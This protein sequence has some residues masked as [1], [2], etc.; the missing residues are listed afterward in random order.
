MSVSSSCFY[1]N[2]LLF[3]TGFSANSLD[4]EQLMTIGNDFGCFI[5]G[6]DELSPVDSILYKV[7]DV[8]STIDNNGLIIGKRKLY[9]RK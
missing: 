2:L 9:S 6:S 5:I 4:I 1:T 7:R 3:R 8:T